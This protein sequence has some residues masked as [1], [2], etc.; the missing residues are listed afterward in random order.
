MNQLVPCPAC[1]RHVRKMEAVCPFCSA[2][3]FLAHLPKPALP[4]RR[5]G[6]AA[7]FAFGATLMGATSLASCSDDSS[8]GGDGSG[9][10]SAAGAGGE[11]VNQAGSPDMHPDGGTPSAGAATAIYGG[12]PAA[13]VGG[14]E[15]EGG[16]GGQINAGGE[17]GS[18]LP[19]YGGPPGG[20]GSGG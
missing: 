9:G 15:Q 5:L 3:V 19:M 17:G 10:A 1:R 20:A 2:V 6:R 4:S 11:S 18:V 8:P 16:G 13:G 12:A 14:Q 7:T